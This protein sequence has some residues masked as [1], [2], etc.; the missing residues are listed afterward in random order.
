MK[1][2]ICTFLFT[3]CTYV[4]DA[5]HGEAKSTLIISAPHKQTAEVSCGK[6][7]FGMA[8]TGCA[9]AVRI[10]G[11]PYFADGTAIDEHGDA[12]S[13]DGF[14]NSIRKAEVEGTIVNNRFVAKSFKLLPAEKK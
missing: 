10:S 6:C 9:L 13:A 14:C 12:H 4:A 11:K 1:L 8:G 7:K 3:L 2:F 5:Q